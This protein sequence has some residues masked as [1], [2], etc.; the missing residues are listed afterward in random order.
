LASQIVTSRQTVLLILSAL[1][2]SDVQVDFWKVQLQFIVALH[3]KGQL[4][5][6]VQLTLTEVALFIVTYTS[7]TFSELR[8]RRPSSCVL[9]SQ[10]SVFPIGVY[11]S[12]IY[13]CTWPFI[14]LDRKTLQSPSKFSPPYPIADRRLDALPHVRNATRFWTSFSCRAPLQPKI[15]SRSP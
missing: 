8:C 4:G 9:D 10:V 5:E 11:V 6:K 13:I 7:E 15:Q 1:I 2:F 14:R 12:R 3:R